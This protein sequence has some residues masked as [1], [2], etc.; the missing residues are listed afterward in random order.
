MNAR[1]LVSILI[2]NYNYGRFIN[3][4]I[5]S[6]LAQA[7]EHIE[8]IVVDDG[9]TDNSLE[10]VARYTDRVR[11][12]KKENGGQASAFNAGFAASTGEIICFLDSDDLFAPEKVKRVVEVFERQP[13]AGWCFNRLRI[14]GEGVENSTRIQVR[15][16]FGELDGRKATAS[17]KPP[18]LPTAT[19]GMSFRR[20]TLARILPMSELIRITSDNYMKF[21]A[22][23]LTKGWMDSQELSLQRIHGD[24]AYTHRQAGKRRVFGRTGLLTGICLHEQFPVLQP[25]ARAIFCNGLGTLWASGGIDADCAPLVD[26]FLG[27]FA[28]TTR[29]AMR[30]RAACTSAKALL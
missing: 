27:S 18:F 26:S 12:V 19:S 6:A 25:L 17:G 8:I 28:L 4:A 24:N 7:Y 23:S 20:D 30:L 10:V 3:E 2:N 16:R 22:L 29:S 13:Q 1:P 14:F 15:N 9:S 21:V 5:E 11:L